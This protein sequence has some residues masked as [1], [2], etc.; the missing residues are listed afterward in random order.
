[1][2][3][4]ADPAD[5]LAKIRSYQLEIYKN[6]MFS[7]LSPRV[8]TDTVRLEEEAEKYMEP[9]AFHYGEKNIQ[10]LLPDPNIRQW[11]AALEKGQLRVLIG[12][13]FG[14]GR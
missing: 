2:K 1:M 7:N 13:R 14:D 11:P 6:G 10:N 8:T 3:D 5:V 9:R 12:P 4:R